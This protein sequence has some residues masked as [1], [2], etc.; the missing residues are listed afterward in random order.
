MSADE[1]EWQVV[2]GVKYVDCEWDSP[3]PSPVNNQKELSDLAR[4]LQK[5]LDKV[6]EKLA[7]ASKPEEKKP[8]PPRQKKN[9]QA[10]GL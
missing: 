9:R 6:N 1:P 2:N 10:G 8:E 4:E 5:A 7:T 3:P